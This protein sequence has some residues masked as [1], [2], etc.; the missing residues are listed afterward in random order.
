MNRSGKYD[1]NLFWDDIVIEFL[2]VVCV[3][4]D[5][6]W[7]FFYFLSTCSHFFS[8]CLKTFPAKLFLYSSY[9]MNKGS[10]H[11]QFS[12]TIWQWKWS[13]SGVFQF[14]FSWF[15]CSTRQPTKAALFLFGGWSYVEPYLELSG[16]LSYCDRFFISFNDITLY[17]FLFFDLRNFCLKR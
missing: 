10:F 16:F 15:I 7:F 2:L 1:K 14:Y 13:L 12:I 3:L 17:I 8:L 11:K 9:Q 4:T 5:T 6:R